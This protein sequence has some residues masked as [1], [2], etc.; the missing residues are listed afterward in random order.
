MTETTAAAGWPSGYRIGPRGADLDPELVE[1]FRT[2]PVPVIGDCLGRSIG[3][4]GLRPYHPAYAE[5]LCGPAITVRVRP[6]DNLMV[7]KAILLAR[8]GDVIVVDGGAD[9]TQALVGGLMRTS[10]VSRRLGGF[11]IDGAIRDL[12][13]WSA[14]G[15]PVFAAGNTHRGPSKDGP[16]EINVPIA[17][18]G[19]AVN[20]GDLI[21]G[22][23]DGVVAIRPYELASLAARCRAHLTREERI[24]EQNASGVLDEERID[25]ILRAK[26][27]PI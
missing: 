22:D 9:L 11:V 27:L 17:C 20:P 1:A 8:P 23:A 2:F 4:R 19:L 7:H 15:M 3:T 26:G 21:V 18:A 16:G 10:A 24:R 12:A 25:S 13:E 14:G 6:G 5:V